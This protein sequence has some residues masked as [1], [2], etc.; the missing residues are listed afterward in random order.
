MSWSSVWLCDSFGVVALLQACRSTSYAHM[1]Y[2]YAYIQI[3]PHTCTCVYVAYT[4]R[5]NGLPCKWPTVQSPE[6]QSRILQ[7][8]TTP[9]GAYLGKKAKQHAWGHLDK[10]WGL[11]LFAFANEATRWPTPQIRVQCVAPIYRYT[12]MHV[13]FT[14]PQSPTN[15]SLPVLFGERNG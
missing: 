7:N 6:F 8:R 12:Y 4:Y 1:A 2:S 13:Q 15:D 11:G 14:A 3:Y 5:S 9:L 10:A